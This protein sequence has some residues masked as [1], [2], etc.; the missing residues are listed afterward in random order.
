MYDELERAAGVRPR[1]GLSLLG[2]LGVGLAFFGL[3]GVAGAVV[4]VR[5]VDRQFEEVATH[6]E[7][8]SEAPGEFRNESLVAQTVSRTLGEL[9]ALPAVDQA[10]L[11]R[12]V[13][14]ALADLPPAVSRRQS[15][16]PVEGTF[17]LKIGDGEIS[18]DLRADDE[19]GSLVVRDVDGRTLLDL[20][21]DP[22]GGHLVIGPEGEVARIEA[23][24]GSVSAPRWLP[25][26]A[27]QGRDLQ[28]VVSG[29]AGGAEF[30]A[31]TWSSGGDP[32]RIVA[33]YRA[34]LEQEGWTIE[35]EHRF[36]E[37][38]DENASFVAHL[39]EADQVIV[40]A[41]G[42]DEGET[43]VVLGWGESESRR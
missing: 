34:D 17:R 36:E 25:S 26:P 27:D 8:W 42:T 21:A 41:A 22:E 7:A 28:R 24:P 2:W 40:F 5:F 32:A 29:R 30:G 38:S 13:R 9:D 11:A 14:T 35:S 18:A 6:L 4:A 23:G 16:E 1:A 15:T 10:T 19:G 39:E 12:S 37:G 31:V 33:R 20:S 43:R 3:V